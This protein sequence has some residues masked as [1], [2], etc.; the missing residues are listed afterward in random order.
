RAPDGGGAEEKPARGKQKGQRADRGQRQ[1][2]RQVADVA[3]VAAGRLAAAEIRPQREG[4]KE[5]PRLQDR[6]HGVDRGDGEKCAE[7][8]PPPSCEGPGGADRQQKSV[9]KRRSRRVQREG[10]MGREKGGGERPD[11][12][13]PGQEKAKGAERGELLS[14][15]GASP[16]RERKRSRREADEEKR[17][18]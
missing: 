5:A 16:G 13:T 1:S 8:K 10:P 18:Q 11:Q 9:K 7:Q 12:S 3:D 15:K 2:D 4:V 17:R 6:N 14:S